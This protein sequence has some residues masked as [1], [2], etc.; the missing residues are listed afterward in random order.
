MIVAAGARRADARRTQPVFAPTNFR[1]AGGWR[2]N[3]RL[4]PDGGRRCRCRKPPI[5]DR[6]GLG[7]NQA[8]S[9]G[10]V[11]EKAPVPFID[12]PPVRKR[13]VELP[14]AGS[15]RRSARRA[16]VGAGDGAGPLEIDLS[17]LREISARLRE[18]DFRGTAVLADGRLLDFEPGNTEADAFAVALDI[19]TTTLVA[20]LLDLGAGSPLGGRCEAQ[21]ANPLR[22]RRPFAHPA[23]P[24]ERPTGCGS[25]TKRSRRPSTK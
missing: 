20:E 12:D 9:S 15:R 25:C 17:L 13:Y 8:E 10:D 4:R 16:A 24:A 2:V 11:A 3:R 6:E 23:R 18:A 5:P 14:R 21:S 19:G 1:P 22:R 7:S